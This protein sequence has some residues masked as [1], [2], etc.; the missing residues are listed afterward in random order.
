MRSILWQA[1]SVLSISTS[2]L[3]HPL[4]LDKRQSCANPA[5]QICGYLCCVEGQHCAQGTTSDNM[6]WVC[7]PDNGDSSNQFAG[8]RTYTST[9]VFTEVDVSTVLSVYSVLIPAATQTVYGP[10]VVVATTTSFPGGATTIGAVSGTFVAPLAPTGTDGVKVTYSISS[11]G[12]FIP[13]IATG[14]LVPGVIVG[15]TAGG[16]GGLTAGQIGGIIGGIIG[17]LGLLALLLLWCCLYGLCAAF[18]RR[19]GGTDESR[20]T[21]IVEHHPAAWV[22][23][24]PGGRIIASR[25]G[26]GAG[27]AAVGAGAIAANRRRRTEVVSEKR[28]NNSHFGRYALI[29]GSLGSYLLYEKFIKS[30]TTDTSTSYSSAQG[31]AAGYYK[32]TKYAV[33]G[34]SAVSGSSGSYSSSSSSSSSSS[35]SGSSSGSS[36][37]FSHSSSSSG[38]RS[39]D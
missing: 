17:G 15:A 22:R 39:V 23:Y 1:L 24:V 8:W 12:T 13:A 9:Y 20:S 4:S 14:T 19:R 37:Y 6:G 38:V 10:P 33:A 32:P 3:A 2:I 29:V 30:R 34:A 26:L 7:V 28:N 11:T 21:V 31:G 16:G 18:R 25:L 27:A 36:S 5:Y 35:G